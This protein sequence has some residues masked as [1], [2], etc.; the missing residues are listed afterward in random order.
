MIFGEVYRHGDE[1]KFN[2]MGQGTTDANLNDL[3]GRYR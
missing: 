3:A 1:W 2:A